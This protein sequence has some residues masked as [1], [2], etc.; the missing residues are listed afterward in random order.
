MKKVTKEMDYDDLYEIVLKNRADKD[1]V[2]KVEE[3]KPDVNNLDNL[4]KAMD[5]LFKHIEK[6]S[7][8]AVLTDCDADGL[9]SSAVIY[10]Y[11]RDDLKHKNLDYITHK[12]NKC[13]GIKLDEI[14]ADK[15][16]L[17][18]VPDAGT[19]DINE[20]INLNAKKV[21]IIVLDHHTLSLS[22]DLKEKGVT[23]DDSP[24]I[25]VNNQISGI[26]INLSGVG[27]V[28]RFLEY[29]NQ[30]KKINI[31]IEK[32]LDLVAIGMI[33]DVM[34]MNDVEVQ[35]YVQKG[36]FNIQNPF[37]NHIIDNTYGIDRF[38][39]NPFKASYNISPIFN[40]IIRMEG[41]ETR[42]ELFECFI[43]DKPEIFT[44]TP[45]SGKNKGIEREENSW[46]RMIRISSSSRS[47]QQTLKKN[48]LKEFDKLEIN[49]DENVCI[50]DITGL[51]ANNT[52]G[53]VASQ[54]V[55]KY[56]KS[57]LMLSKREIDGYSCYAGSARGV[58]GL[59]L[60]SRLEKSGLFK[61]IAGHEGAF[62]V[63]IL[64]EN[65]PKL[66][67]FIKIN[68]TTEDCGE[69]YNADFEI[70][71]DTYET[72]KEDLFNIA[73]EIHKYIGRNFERI[74]VRLND[75]EIEDVIFEKY[76]RGSAIVLKDSNGNYYK[77]FKDEEYFNELTDCG[78]NVMFNCDLVGEL[79][80][81]G[82]YD[83][84]NI[85][86]I[87]VNKNENEDDIDEDDVW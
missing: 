23:I 7:N 6:N 39:L 20:H 70:D 48:S 85:N 21:D 25:I 76:T 3:F 44:F 43:I 34:T 2:K 47:R 78:F 84:F 79:E 51:G 13:H 26:S 10:R 57:I 59:N 73:E 49:D 74:A 50:L 40:A 53:M 27:I 54:L 60:K 55:D 52:G 22:K 8:I 81:N 45:S 24:A 15:I 36:I 61:L 30:S 63:E 72:I 69:N 82:E 67:E 38:S 46:E 58:N 66:K 28:Y 37:L 17:L 87:I 35:Y 64:E 86:S 41:Y 83:N 77:C 32:Y 19:S 1:F 5:M 31:N 16:D 33:A 9:T 80:R 4:D 62:G 12:D 71:Y 68:F 11:L 56:K 75:I 65:L 29:I 18:I 42:K 14:K